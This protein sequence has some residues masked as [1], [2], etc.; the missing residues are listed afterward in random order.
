MS[1]FVSP[2]AV[3]GFR[4][5]DDANANAG[6]GHGSHVVAI[7][8]AVA[9]APRPGHLIQ[10]RTQ[11]VGGGVIADERVSASHLVVAGQRQGYEQNAGE[12][13]EELKYQ[14]CVLR[15]FLQVFG[16]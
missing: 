3:R 2:P 12:R 9:K 7:P 5:I 13:L 10:A 6:K 4:K 1:D 16:D 8:V 11:R 15:M 14:V